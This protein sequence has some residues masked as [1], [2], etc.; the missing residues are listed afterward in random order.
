MIGQEEEAEERYA[1]PS[2]LPASAW[3]GV[4]ESPPY[5]FLRSGAACAYAPEA[6]TATA[7]YVASSYIHRE[8]TA[9]ACFPPAE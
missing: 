3:H 6:R 1:L 5:G 4:T 9:P 2:F 7:A 8:R